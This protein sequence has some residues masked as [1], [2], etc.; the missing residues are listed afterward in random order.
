MRWLL[1]AAAL[2]LAACASIGRPEGGPKDQLPPVFKYSNPAPE[3]RNVKNTTLDFYFDE[4]VQLQDAFNKVIVSPVQKENPKVQAN[5]R[6]VTVE[7][8]DTLLPNTTYTI[9]FGDAIKDLNEGNI[10]DGFTAAF[11]TGDSIDTLRIAGIVLEAQTLEPAQGVLVGVYSCPEDTALADSTISTLPFERVARTNQLG[12]FAIHNLKPGQYMVYALNDINRD[13]FWDRTEDVAFY[14]IPVS[15]YATPITV[16][17][18]LRAANNSDSLVARAG[19]AYF[20]NDVLLCWF[21]EGYQS[22]Y[23]KDYARPERRRITIN[24]SAPADSL[25]QITIAKG[26]HEGLPIEDWSLLRKNATLDS[27]EYWISDSTILAIDSLMLSVK[28]LRTDTNDLLTWRAD[29]LK[30]FW[31]EPKRK[32]DKKKKKKD[33]EADT[34]PPPTEFINFSALTSRTQEYNRPVVFKCDVPIDSIIDAGVRL[35]I[36]EDTLWLPIDNVRF[37]IDSLNPLTQRKIY[38]PWKDGEQYR[39]TVDSASVFG[40]YGLHNNKISHE[41]KVK[42]IEEYS[43]LYFNVIGLDTLPAVVELL[44]RSDKVIDRAPVVNGKASLK[45]LKPGQVYARLFIDANANGKWDTG[46]IALKLQPEEVFYYPKKLNLRQN[47]DIN[48]DWNIYEVTVDM[49]KPYDIKKN[50]PKLKAGEKGP[51]QSDDEEDEEDEFASP[52]GPY[53]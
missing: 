18:T 19:T 26:A 52:F 27:L 7:I 43:N 40:I 11:S 48:Q 6:R 46:N 41:F 24:M 53:Y 15:P 34:L 22:Q 21:N 35:E 20:P 28:Y 33:E 23:L 25:P 4:N 38:T 13:Y 5:G 37:E 30:F 29:T 10:L 16:V 36:K 32:E 49:Q 51:N 39:L 50:K 44:D 31:K 45:Y 2:A 14:D 1:Y 9:D 42:S 3:A 12:Q 17:D 8:K 47:W